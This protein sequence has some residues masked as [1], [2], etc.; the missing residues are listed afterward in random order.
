MRKLVERGV[1][2]GY[3]AVVSARRLG[4]DITAFIRVTVDGSENYPE[5][6]ALA[7]ETEDVGRW[8][9]IDVGGVDTSTNTITALEPVAGRFGPD[10]S[11]L[12]SHSVAMLRVPQVTDLTVT[13]TLSAVGS[14]STAGDTLS[15]S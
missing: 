8:T 11:Q 2:E 14:I 12:R 15:G 1:L 6:V 9:L 4:F 10:S 7:T 5:F 3:H 13:G